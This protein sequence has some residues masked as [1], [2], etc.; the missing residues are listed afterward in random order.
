M[1]ARMVCGNDRRQVAVSAPADRGNDLQAVA[2]L[3]HADAKLAARHDFAV[4]FHGDAF[5]GEPQF[6]D[7]VGAARRVVE[8]ARFTIDD[9]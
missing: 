2:V 9:D 4:A 6:M 3:Q 7:Q 1:L 5:A 8:G